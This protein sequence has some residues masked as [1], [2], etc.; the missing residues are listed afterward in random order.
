MNITLKGWFGLSAL[1]IM[2]IACNVSWIFPHL[3]EQEMD[4]A[5]WIFQW[6]A[7]CVI[8]YVA[9]YC[10]ETKP[11]FSR[12]IWRYLFC[13]SLIMLLA[14]I[15]DNP[16]EKKPWMYIAGLIVGIYEYRQFKLS[17]NDNS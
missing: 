16:T 10:L 6:T 3:T 15:F 13:C 7:S 11:S 5:Y 17:K 9:C 8:I 14:E 2:F 1:I 12:F 4:K